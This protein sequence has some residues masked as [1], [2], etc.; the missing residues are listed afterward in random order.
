MYFSEHSFE[1]E[2][3]NCTPS[4]VLIGLE[5]GKESSERTYVPNPVQLSFHVCTFSYNT[6]LLHQ[7]AFRIACEA[8]WEKGMSNLTNQ[9]L[10]P[11]QIYFQRNTS[12]TAPHTSYDL[13][14]N[15]VLDMYIHTYK[16]YL[17]RSNWQ[18]NASA[19]FKQVCLGVHKSEKMILQQTARGKSS[20]RSSDGG[21]GGV[22]S[23]QVLNSNT[24]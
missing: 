1:C 19:F 24:Q 4:V 6:S 5:F 13:L 3:I 23:R 12:T 8:E 17:Q 22:S 16:R 10:F 15:P 14:H 11:I 2:H 7:R 21:G 18:I 20:C 9:Q